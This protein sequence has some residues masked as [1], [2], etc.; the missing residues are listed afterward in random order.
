MFCVKIVFY[1]ILIKFTNSEAGID[2]LKEEEMFDFMR[3]AFNWIHGQDHVDTCFI[4]N[5]GYEAPLPWPQV[6]KNSVP[7]ID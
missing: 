4:L 2:V 7:Q 1:L 3:K 6:C 5:F